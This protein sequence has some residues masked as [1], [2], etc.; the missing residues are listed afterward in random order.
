MRL[1]LLLIAIVSVLQSYGQDPE[2]LREQALMLCSPEMKGRGYVDKG[3]TKAAKALCKEFKAIGL[4]AFD[5]EYEQEFS[6]TVNT[7]PNRMSVSVEGIEL[8]PGE[9]FIV[10]AT[11]PSVHGEYRAKVYSGHSLREL[12]DPSD[13]AESNKGSI[14]VLNMADVDD[15]NLILKARATLQRFSMYVPV[16]WAGKEKLTWAVANHQ[17][18]QAVIESTRPEL[19]FDDALVKLDIKAELKEGFKSKNIIGY[20]QGT[21]KPDSMVFFTAHYD[22]L[23]MM[24]DEAC[25]YGA[26]DNASGT[27]FILSLA[28]YYSENPPEFTIVFIAFAGE[29][30]GLLGSKHFVEFSPVDL[31]KIRMVINMDLMA[32]GIDGITVVNAIENDKEFQW[33]LELNEENEYL[34]KINPRKQAANSDH[35]YFAEAGIPAVFIYAL[36][37]SK[38]YHDIHDVGENLTFDEYS[39]I[40]KLL[41]DLVEKF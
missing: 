2:Y 11:A 14:L 24:G 3:V 28:K 15:K 31:S 5:G 37:G 26:N 12:R 10:S 13:F 33:L 27:A 20:I 21:T 25:F 22:H 39:D 1:G 30:A 38:A 4:E 8:I 34:P 16:I 36:G 35:Y 29:E 41:T 19:F 23:G 32:S 17:S 6:H 7:F 18:D 40:F 9:D